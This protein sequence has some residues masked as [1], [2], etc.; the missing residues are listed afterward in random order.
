MVDLQLIY[1]GFFTQPSPAFGVIDFYILNPL[2]TVLR[3]GFKVADLT[4][5]DRLGGGNYGQVI[6]SE[7]RNTSMHYHVTGPASFMIR[8]SRDEADCS[9]KLYLHVTPLPFSTVFLLLFFL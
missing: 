2:D 7:L 5:R 3:K 1:Y 9:L 6:P 8:L 4:L